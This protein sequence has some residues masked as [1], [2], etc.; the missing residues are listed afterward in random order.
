MKTKKHK[1]GSRKLGGITDKNKKYTPLD[2]DSLLLKRKRLDEEIEQ[3]KKRRWIR[4]KPSTVRRGG[5]YVKK[6]GKV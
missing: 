3:A 2:L 6:G 4:G 1:T 5:K